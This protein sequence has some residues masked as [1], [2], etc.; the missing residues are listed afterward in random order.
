MTN[1]YRLFNEVE[2]FYESLLDT[3]SSASEVISMMYLIYDHGI[4]SERL[5]QVLREKCK[6][7]VQVRIMTDFFGTFTD[8]PANIIRNMEMFR[9]LK[10]AGVQVSL[11]NPSA[12]GTSLFDRLHIKLCA[13][14]NTTI[15]MGG[16]NIGDYYTNW[17]DTNLRIDGALGMVGHQI[18]DLVAASSTRSKNMHAYDGKPE[19]S[20]GISCGDA[21]VLL[22]V[23][24]ANR[25][26]YTC[27]V[28]FIQTSRSDVYLRYWYFLPN[29]AILDAICEKLKNGTR[30]NILL[31][32]RTRV[33]VIDVLNKA[34]LRRLAEAGASVFRFQNKYMHS[35]VAWSEEG[36]V[37]IG[38]A[39][40]EKTGMKHNF[41][42][43]LKIQNASLAEQLSNNFWKDASESWQ[44]AAG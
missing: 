29:K 31:S 9:S 39:N 40:M 28:D 25:D 1:T 6:A 14:D 11:F 12:P 35:K 15:H 16:S 44:V 4:W 43:C 38:S 41:E 23:P 26:I 19:Y 2:P 27:L 3:V 30:V 7:G 34:P 18:F 8:H 36:K 21:Q 32:N 5:N 17:L 10:G 42:L 33:P 22:T 37:I 13:V 24:G 20:D